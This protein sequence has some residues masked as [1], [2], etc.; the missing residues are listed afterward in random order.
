VAAADAL[1]EA[2]VLDPADVLDELDEE[3]QAAAA[4][5]SKTKPATANRA[6]G[7]RYVNM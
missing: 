1:L 2:D 6:R 4:S 7:D 5:P 3:L